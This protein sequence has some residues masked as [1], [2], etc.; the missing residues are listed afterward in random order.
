MSEEHF[1]IYAVGFVAMSLCTSIKDTEEIERRANME[2]P[3]G[4]SSGWKISDESHFRSGQ[5]NPCK[6]EQGMEAMH[7]LMVC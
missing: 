4:I 1:E 2:Q 3:T 7:Y 6:C 5:T